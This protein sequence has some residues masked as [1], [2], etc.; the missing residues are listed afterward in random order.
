[1]EVCVLLLL[2]GAPGELR[3]SCTRAGAQSLMLTCRWVLAQSLGSGAGCSLSSTCI[4][5]LPGQ[6]DVSLLSSLSSRLKAE[7]C[8]G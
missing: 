2:Q 4:D 5:S 1:M 8:Q 6:A 7:H 3:P